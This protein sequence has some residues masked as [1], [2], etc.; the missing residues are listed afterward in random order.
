M[1][2]LKNYQ[3]IKN[4]IEV[5]LCYEEMHYFAFPDFLSFFP[6]RGCAMQYVYED[7]TAIGRE[8]RAGT[9]LRYPLF[10]VRSLCDRRV[11]R[12]Q[13]VEESGCSVASS[14]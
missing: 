8:A 9:K 6:Q 11:Y 5:P 13:V 2:V 3:A 7:R 4:S 10:D 12:L 1:Q 14:A